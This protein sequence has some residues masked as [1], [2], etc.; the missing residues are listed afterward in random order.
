M[1][2]L[3][4]IMAFLVLALSVMPCADTGVPAND[5]KPKTELAKSNTQKGDTHKDDTQQDDCSPFCHC[6]CCAGF[7][8]NHFI[9]SVVHISPYESSTKTP[10]LPSSV[11]D[12]ALPVWQPP[13]LV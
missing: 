2:I 9:A 5:G 8:I 12:V 13:Q 4:F 1:K 7:S 10:H 3:A 11:L 6:A